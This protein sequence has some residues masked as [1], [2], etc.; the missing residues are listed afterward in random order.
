MFFRLV[1][2]HFFFLMFKLNGSISLSF[3]DLIQLEGGLSKLIGVCT[4]LYIFSKGGM[5]IVLYVYIY[6]F[7]NV[8]RERRLPAS[9]VGTC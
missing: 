8:S 2:V 5:C 6:I 4:Y 7:K 3:F 1:I 9:L